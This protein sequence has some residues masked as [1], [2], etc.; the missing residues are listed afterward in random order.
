MRCLFLR[1]KLRSSPL[2]ANPSRLDRMSASSTPV[3]APDGSAPSSQVE[4]AKSVKSRRARRVQ[5]LASSTQDRDTTEQKTPAKSGKR[6]PG[7]LTREQKIAVECG[8]LTIPRKFL[9]PEPSACAHHFQSHFEE[10]SSGLPRPKPL[11]TTRA[12]LTHTPDEK[13]SFP[14]PSLPLCPPPLTP[15]ACPAVKKDAPLRRQL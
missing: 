11:C 15:V 7:R 5:Q 4:Q 10:I 8:I 2:E 9:L 6:L 14:C 12:P 1:H 3:S 13:C